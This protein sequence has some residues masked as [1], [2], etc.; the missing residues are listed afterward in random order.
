MDNKSA[1]G[2]REVVAV[3]AMA[4][5]CLV[6]AEA[7]RTGYS[8][9]IAVCRATIKAHAE[10][11][12]VAPVSI[13]DEMD[14]RIVER[15]SISEAIAG[16]RTTIRVLAGIR[17]SYTGAAGRRGAA[18]PAT[19]ASSAIA[20]AVGPPRPVASAPTAAAAAGAPAPKKKK[21]RKRKKKPAA[22][23]AESDSE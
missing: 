2:R 8:Q 14:A 6:T 16:L 18:A 15:K 5:H 7:E 9:R 13:R 21:P 11:K 4:T 17:D 3:I 23:G 22:R 12:R 10:S 19:A 20:P 1:K